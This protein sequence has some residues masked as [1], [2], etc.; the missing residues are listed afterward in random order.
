[1]LQTFR[2]N[3]WVC[4]FTRYCSRCLCFKPPR[5]HHCGFCGRCTCRYDHHC[6]WIAQCVGH[7]NHR[8]FLG[9]LF[10]SVVACTVGSLLSA[11][12]FFARESIENIRVSGSFEST[13]DLDIT[14]SLVVNGPLAVVLAFFSSWHLYLLASGQTTLELENN[15]QRKA[16]VRRRGAV[17]R[18]VFDRGSWQ[19]NFEVAFGSCSVWSWLFSLFHRL[20][21]D[22]LSF[23]SVYTDEGLGM[24]DEV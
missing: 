13:A 14:I 1:M 16:R 17:A 7:H 5:A 2:N 20:P 18:N 8:Y 9:F 23:D 10:Y 24:N 12:L 3:R 22:G 15:H 6:P 21:S 4:R 11:P 19:K